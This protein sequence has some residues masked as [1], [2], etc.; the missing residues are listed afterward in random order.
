[1]SAQ[2][3]LN[4]SVL[5]WFGKESPKERENEIVEYEGCVLAVPWL[6]LVRIMEIQHP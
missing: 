4:Y 3:T 2:T 5:L 1:M 6:L